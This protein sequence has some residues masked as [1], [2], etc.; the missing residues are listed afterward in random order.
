[1]VGP[2]EHVTFFYVRFDGYAFH[3]SFVHRGI[4]SVTKKTLRGLCVLLANMGR[5]IILSPLKN[6]K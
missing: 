4:L 3:L 1:M 2:L 6:T 5:E